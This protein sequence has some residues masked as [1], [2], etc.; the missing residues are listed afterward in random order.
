TLVPLGVVRS[1]LQFRPQLIFSNSFGIWTILALALKLLL[2]WQV[3][4]AYEGSAPGVDF[5]NSPKRLLLRRIMVK[6]ADALISNSQSGKNYLIEV[7]Q[8]D[9]AK[10]FAQPYEIPAAESLAVDSE[11]PL[12]V[13]CTRPIFLFVGRI[14]PRKGLRVLL[15]ACQS[16]KERGYDRFT[17]LVVGDGEQ[18]QE[19]QDLSQTYH[20]NDCV[21]WLGR[22][23]YDQVSHYFQQADVFV[24]PTFEDTWGVVVL[25]AMLLGK[26]VLCSLGAGS[27]EL[28]MDGENGYRFEP[29]QPEILAGQMQQFIDHP[30]QAAQMGDRAQQLMQAH[31]PT[32]AA[33]FLADVVHFAI[34]QPSR[35]Q[36][37]HS[38]SQHE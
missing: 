13:D 1:L 17:L 25:E 38:V 29:Q 22:V 6:W 27:S 28:V 33:Q 5:R 8:A 30:D 9:P 24:L 34:H 12:S 14:M 32:I 23:D 10:V 35:L 31:T 21:Q 3:V 2:S 20:L 18:R 7:L 37:T 11:L 19:L 4:I 36:Q 16:L 15:E 26:P